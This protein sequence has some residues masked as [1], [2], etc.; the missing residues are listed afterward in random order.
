MKLTP[1]TNAAPKFCVSLAIIKKDRF[2]FLE[3]ARK[4]PKSCPQR[5][6]EYKDRLITGY[7]RVRTN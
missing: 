2:F 7:F 5:K 6:K 3:G 4:S 1:H